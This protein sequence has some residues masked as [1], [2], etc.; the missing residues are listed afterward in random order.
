MSEKN[1]PYINVNLSNVNEV[2]AILD[3]AHEL[4]D[5]IEA[6]DYQDSNGNLLKNNAKHIELIAKLPKRKGDVK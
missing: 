5:Q 1:K 3:T 6:G 2:V 4:V